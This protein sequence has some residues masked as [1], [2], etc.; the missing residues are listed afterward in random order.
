VPLHHPK[1]G[2][3]HVVGQ[4]VTLSRTPASIVSTLPELGS[5]TDEI[6]RGAGYSDTEIADF[7]ARKIV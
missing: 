4:P 5:H 6:L 3:I 2:N 7:H 1:R